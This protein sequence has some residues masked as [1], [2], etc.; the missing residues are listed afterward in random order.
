MKEQ[1]TE[2]SILAKVRDS[3][4]VKVMVIGVLMLIMLIPASMVENLIRERQYRK[5]EAVNEISS[6]WG[7]EQVLLGPVITL[8]YQII[9][10][11]SVTDKKGKTHVKTHT[12]TNYLYILPEELE[13]TGDLKPE[14]RYRGIYKAVLYSVDLQIKGSFVDFR[15]KVEEL[16]GEHILWNKAV[17][18][19]GITDLRGIRESAA[20]KI[21]NIEAPIE[22]GTGMHGITNSGLNTKVNGLETAEKTAFDINLSLNGS[23]QISFIPVGKTTK[24]D[25][26]SPWDSPSF[27]GAYL[28]VERNISEN[29]FSA[30]WRVFEF[31]RNYP[32]ILANSSC[33]LN[34]SAF[35]VR[36]FIGNDIYQQ[37]TRTVKYAVLFI[38]FTFATIFLA[39]IISRTRVHPFQYL[40]TGL[41]VS[42]FYV[43]LIS[44]SEHLPFSKAYLMSSIA[45][46]VLIFSYVKAIFKK[47]VMPIVI[48]TIQIVLYVY[49]YI[50]LQSEDYALLLGSLGLFTLL[51]VV[52]YVTRKINWNKLDYSHES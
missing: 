13:I 52:M 45:I 5:F 3:I 47:L 7:R 42:I 37:S 24:V 8:P 26:T 19:V 27:D 16:G 50:T 32:Q 25:I 18:S 20:I 34:Q 23:Q 21:N 49:F 1:E 31:N 36:L 28:P 11:S 35:G 44:I 6:K 22:A 39:E 9:T 10:K 15:K 51:A 38:V 33:D 12:R 48:A 14:I 41:A 30:K 29:G 4:I 40:M 2:K 46:V 17:L 43:L